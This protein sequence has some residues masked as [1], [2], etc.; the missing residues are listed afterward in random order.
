MLARLTSASKV[1]ACYVERAGLNILYASR[2][3]LAVDWADGD[4]IM[5]A[6]NQISSIGNACTLTSAHPSATVSLKAQKGEE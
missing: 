6:T 1:L 5:C 3:G 2:G 4:Q